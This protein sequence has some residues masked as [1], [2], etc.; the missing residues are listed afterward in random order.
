MDSRLSRRNFLRGSVSA[1]GMLMARDL[2]GSVPPQIQEGSDTS[3]ERQRLKNETFSFITRCSREDGGYAPSPDPTYQ[4]NSDTRSSDLAAVTYAATLARSVGWR[5][6]RE[7]LTAE[8]IQHHQQPDGSFI[9]HGGKFDPKGELGR[10][11]I[12]PL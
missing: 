11:Y 8:F 9:N 10:L 3:I 1:T 7:E 6:P 2:H 5:L 4:G 12:T